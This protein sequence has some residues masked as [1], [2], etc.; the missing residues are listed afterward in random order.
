MSTENETIEHEAA[1]RIEEEEAL[2][3][4][5]AW[6]AALNRAVTT[7]V[8]EGVDAVASRLSPGR[9]SAIRS[10]ASFSSVT[11]RVLGFDR[12]PK[13]NDRE[14]KCEENGRFR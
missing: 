12:W 4:D 7:A 11:G 1:N 13:L 2:A 3:R 10:S 14:D 6:R 9:T 5:P 8:F